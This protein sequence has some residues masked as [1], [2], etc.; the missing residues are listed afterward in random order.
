MG[1]RGRPPLQ[2][3]SGR[4]ADPVEGYKWLVLAVSRAP[5]GWFGAQAKRLLDSQAEKLTREQIAEAQRWAREWGAA[6]PQPEDGR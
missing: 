6:H 1:R 4:A 2:R 3:A 5:I